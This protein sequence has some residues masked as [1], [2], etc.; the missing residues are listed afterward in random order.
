MIANLD[1][2]V[3]RTPCFAVSERVKKY[4]HVPSR[5]HSQ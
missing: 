3:M 1:N 5:F 2:C 4:N